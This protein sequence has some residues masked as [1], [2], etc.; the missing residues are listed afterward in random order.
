M[1]EKEPKNSFNRQASAEDVAEKYKAEIM[2]L[3]KGSN[4]YSI[5]KTV[6]AMAVPASPVNEPPK[7]SDKEQVPIPASPLPDIAAIPQV[8]SV[9][10]TTCDGKENCGFLQ[11]EVTTG[12]GAIPIENAH[13][14]VLQINGTEKIA[15]RFMT[16]DSNGETPTISLPAP[17]RKLSEVP[18]NVKP[19]ATYN[20]IAVAE[21]F[22]RMENI[23]APV[24]ATIKSI[25]PVDLVPLAEYDE[26]PKKVI[27]Y[28]QP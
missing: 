8:D 26:N 23:N 13:V 15:H 18:G 19:Y 27:V 4:N 28:T 1:T 2:R 5:P 24:F 21:G 20:I 12:K 22:Y 17:S 3:Y 14:T 16:T 25:L 6:P 9:E 7:I 11:V 10:N